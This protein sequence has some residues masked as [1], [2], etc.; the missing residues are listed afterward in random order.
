MDLSW[1]E[2]DVT[3]KTFIPT[4]M[5]TSLV[6]DPV[7]RTGFPTYTPWS[8]T[9]SQVVVHLT[10]RQAGQCGLHQVVICQL[11]IGYYGEFSAYT[12][13]TVFIFA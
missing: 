7:V 4:D 5:K 12:E 1:D 2:A 10:K 11:Y 9:Q 13:G 3:W 6:L 8:R